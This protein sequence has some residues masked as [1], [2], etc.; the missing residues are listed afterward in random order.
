[1]VV[2]SSEEV[3]NVFLCGRTKADCTSPVGSG[4]T[5]GDEIILITV[6]PTKTAHGITPRFAAYY[7]SHPLFSA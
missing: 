1:M 5:G 4:E 6:F 7:R 2:R 3:V